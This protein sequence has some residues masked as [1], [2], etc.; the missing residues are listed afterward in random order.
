MFANKRTWSPAHCTVFKTRKAIQHLLINDL[1]QEALRQTSEHVNRRRLSLAEVWPTPGMTM[2][3]YKS[4]TT[5]FGTLILGLFYESNLF[6]LVFIIHQS[7]LFV[8]FF[9]PL[10]SVHRFQLSSCDPAYLCSL[11]PFFCLFI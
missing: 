11:P 6:M 5:L 10:F 8:C 1:E 7:T 9:P 3:T 2:K 4:F